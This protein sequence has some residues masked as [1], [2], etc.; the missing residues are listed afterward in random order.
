MGAIGMEIIP[1]AIEIDG[2]KE[3]AIEAVFGTIGLGLDEEH[4]FGEAIR[5]VGFLGVAIPDIVFFERD[6]SEFWVRADGS[7][8]DEFFDFADACL[9]DELDA[10]HKIFVEEFAGVDAI[11]TD[12]PYYRGKMNYD[13]GFHIIVHADAIGETDEIIILDFRDEYIFAAAFLKALN[14]KRAEE[15]GTAGDYD[16]FIFKKVAHNFLS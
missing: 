16:T 10:H 14:Y 1:R 9:V 11:S 15:A 8:G 6:G 7:Y 12:T 3:Y 5:G 4:F 2:E 13:I